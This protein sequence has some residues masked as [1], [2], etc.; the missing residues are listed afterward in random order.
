MSLIGTNMHF[1]RQP[2]LMITSFIN[3]CIFAIISDW[4]HGMYVIHLITGLCPCIIKVGG[5]HLTCG[6]RIIHLCLSVPCINVFHQ[7]P[8]TDVYWIL[9]EWKMKIYPGDVGNMSEYT[10]VCTAKCYKTTGRT[11]DFKHAI[12]AVD[13]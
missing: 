7:L 8:F 1:T 12:H 6:S 9:F 13:S 2:E 5:P 11:V 4:N 10:A 3:N